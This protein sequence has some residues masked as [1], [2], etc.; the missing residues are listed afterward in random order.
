MATVTYKLP[1][2]FSSSLG[3]PDHQFSF[4]LEQK[5]R[6][7]N[8]VMKDLK[9][10]PFPR[11]SAE[12]DML[13]QEIFKYGQQ[14]QRLTGNFPEEAMLF[15]S[16]KAS[17]GQSGNMQGEVA[18]VIETAQRRQ[19]DPIG[20]QSSLMKFE[21]QTTPYKTQFLDVPGTMI[22]WIAGDEEGGLPATL[23]NIVQDAI[24]FAKR[25][26]PRDPK[27]SG[28]IATVIAADIGLALA[29][30]KAGK[31][32]TPWGPSFEQFLMPKVMAG[33]NKISGGGTLSTG[34]A[35]G[36]T[37][38]LASAA[39]DL[40]YNWANRSYRN[41]F[42]TAFEMTEDG[43][44]KL[45][46]D[47]NKIPKQPS[48]TEDMLQTMNSAMFEAAFS[49]G[50]AAGILGAQ[51]LWKNF[52]SKGTGIDPTDLSQQQ[53]QQL[54]AQYNIPMS[55]IA[56]SPSDSLKGFSR[57][58]GVFPFV[59]G[60]LRQAQDQSRI[61]LNK[62]IQKTF[63]ELAPYHKTVDIVQNLGDKGYKAFKENF[64]NFSGMKA[65]LYEA[66]DD[67]AEE[68]T[69]S[70]IP[71]SRLRNY[72]SQIVP[73]TAPDVGLSQGV[74]VGQRYVNTVREALEAVSGQAGQGDN[75][76]KALT[77]L[78]NMPE[79]LS[80]KEFRE[81]Q[82]L[83]NDAIRNLNPST[84]G[85]S[86][87]SSPAI[88]KILGLVSKNLRDDLDDVVNW[89]QMSGK[90]QVLAEVA[91][92][93]LNDANTFFF[94]NKDDFASFFA[95]TGATRVGQAIETS[96][97]ARFFQPNAPK[98][99]GVKQ[100]DELFEIFM[101][102]KTMSVSLK[103][104]S[105]LYRQVGPEVFKELANGYMDK[106]LSQFIKIYDTNTIP[107][108]GPDGVIMDQR[109]LIKDFGDVRGVSAGVPVID[110]QGLR[111][112]FGLE[113]VRPG[114]VGTMMA[115]SNNVAMANMF[116]LMGKDGIKAY[117]KLDDLLTL[118]ERV[119]SFDVSDVS[120]FI[121]RR[122][123]LAGPKAI[124]T[125][126]TV[127]VGLANPVGALGM[128]LLTRGISK[129]LASPKAYANM[130]KGLDDTLSPAL[131]R[132]ALIEVVKFVDD[133]IGFDKD[134]G[135][136]EP[137]PIRVAGTD[138]ALLTREEPEAEKSRKKAQK[139]V[140]GIEDFYG[141][142]VDALTVPEMLEYFISKAKEA[143]GS[144]FSQYFG[145]KKNATTG[146]L[147]PV[148]K[149]GG[150]GVNRTDEQNFLL[151]NLDPAEKLAKD[152]FG[153]EEGKRVADFAEAQAKT[154]GLKPAQEAVGSGTVFMPVTGQSKRNFPQGRPV[155]QNFGPNPF[156]TGLSRFYQQNIAPGLNTSLSS[157]NILSNMINTPSAI[158][159]YFRG[160][161][162][163]M[164]F[165]PN[166]R[167]N[168][169]QRIAMADGNINQALAA[170]GFNKGGIVGKVK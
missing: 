155:Q 166:N 40:T 75:A 117:K 112:A 56:S 29:L 32:N 31:A 161:D 60:P 109:G 128:I 36:G 38:G 42:P 25:R 142:K 170:R 92:Q 101:D 59:G 66:Y 12:R 65:A 168:Q 85:V 24:T 79:H 11:N 106:K 111:Q 13:L 39:Y 27:E 137:S 102:P 129:F 26:L 164:G 95:G 45:D 121:Q 35:V 123:V 154:E 140:L 86:M 100:P 131:R 71:T 41:A 104:Q 145:F 37:S 139:T 47:G 107:V 9:N 2:E 57:I 51:K 167:L 21:G 169:N 78:A 62:E 152:I 147:E 110:V 124:T 160:V 34:L 159:Q 105:E 143:P 116:N 6:A 87:G 96:V 126:L 4:E 165:G 84:G 76:V 138:S 61:A 48:I 153:E 103:A 30:R 144:E 82:R 55:I 7:D 23:D 114:E 3:F 53:I 118:A 150:I 156:L 74:D 44:F 135:A 98:A 134:K 15:L 132:D 120:K 52:V 77:A 28:R 8:G 68:I 88:S 63:T 163:R 146:D 130:M 10:S 89:K 80:A 133:E 73:K 72:L 14:Q 122:G 125:G 20:F 162:Q 17:E 67:V 97:D 93:R 58:I 115:R 54:A 108:R 157:G 136:V 70:F 49:G 64:N 50:T 148:K 16:Q 90:N 119:Q 18:K 94:S 113:N 91:K 151:A 149:S 99:P 22:P 1:G 19:D 83:V 127:G 5:V 81:V 43:Q 46:A 141:K 33:L 69:E 158:N